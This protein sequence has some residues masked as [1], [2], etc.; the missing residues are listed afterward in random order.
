MNTVRVVKSLIE[1]DDMD[2]YEWGKRKETRK[3]E[4]IVYSLSAAILRES[5]FSQIKRIHLLCSILITAICK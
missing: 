4:N 3:R 2:E 5:G 1:M